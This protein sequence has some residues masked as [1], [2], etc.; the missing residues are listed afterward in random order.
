[1]PRLDADAAAFAQMLT[2][3]LPSGDAWPGEADSVQQQVLL[4]LAHGFAT[5]NSRA[6]HLVTDAFPGTTA[7]LLEEWERSLGLPD[8]CSP[9]ETTIEL[10]RRAVVAKLIA[11]GG[12]AVPYFTA[13]AA[14]LGYSISVEQ[15]A[16]MRA[17]ASE[18]DDVCDGDDWAHAWRVTVAASLAST[19]FIADESLADDSLERFE[20]ELL[21]CRM[22]SVAPAHTVLLFDYAGPGSGAGVAYLTGADDAPLTGA[23]GQMFIAPPL[24]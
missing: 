10:R 17:D 22:R 16:P 6:N 3:L 1:M 9:L 5:L 18:A 14:A 19:V 8:A 15:F 7:E 13:F 12:Q 20:G 2:N 23:D 4:A 11:T 24:I 21:A